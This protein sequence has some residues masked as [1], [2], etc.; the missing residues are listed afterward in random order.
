MASSHRACRERH[1][2]NLYVPLCG[3]FCLRSVD[4]AH[5]AVLIQTKS[6][7]NCDVHLAGSIF[8]TYSN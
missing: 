1:S 4:V 6:H 8:Q 2:Y 5:Y 7:T 3:I